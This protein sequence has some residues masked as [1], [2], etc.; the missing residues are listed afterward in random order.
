MGA[1]FSAETLGAFRILTQVNTLLNFPVTVAN[2]VAPQRI[3]YLW[4]KNRVDEIKRFSI[5]TA[6]V[7]LL[8]GIPCLII[9][10]F[11]RNI[12]NDFIGLGADEIIYIVSLMILCQG[13]NLATGTLNATLT[14]TSHADIA[15]NN[16]FISSAFYI[17][18]FG[19][20]TYYFEL[21]GAISAFSLAIILDN[22][23]GVRSVKRKLGFWL[24]PIRVT[25]VGQN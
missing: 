12:I 6:Q 21:I 16:A 4:G 19:I 18:I 11:F 1:F 23:L 8:I 9:F 25:P 7:T 3:S 13:I 2:I 10:A 15:R 22:I 20:L 17:V 5:S 14:M 24:L